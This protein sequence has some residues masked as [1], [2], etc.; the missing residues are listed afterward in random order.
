[1]NE[2]DYGSLEACKRFVDAGIVMKTKK[3]WIY[4]H[5]I[6]LKGADSTWKLF[7]RQSLM[8]IEVTEQRP[9]CMFPALSMGEAWRELP[10]CIDEQWD[11]VLGKIDTLSY[12]GYSDGEN[13]LSYFK[14]F[15]PTDAL[16]DLLIWVRK[17]GKSKP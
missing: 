17:G 10:G 16:I 12:I 9:Y 4:A 7:D 1:M 3:V 14:S 15:N 8:A 13:W 11:L 2:L 5:H 6:P